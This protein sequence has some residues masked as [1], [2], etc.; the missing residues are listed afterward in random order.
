[1]KITFDLKADLEMIKNMIAENP[2]NNYDK[3]MGFIENIRL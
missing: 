3:V 1:M 2:D